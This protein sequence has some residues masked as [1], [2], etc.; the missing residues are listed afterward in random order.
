MPESATGLDG[1]QE[2]ID[3]ADFST[4][5]RRID[6]ADLETRRRFFSVP[7]PGTTE[8]HLN[9][10][11]R[12]PSKSLGQHVFDAVD[13][14]LF[15]GDANDTVG[16]DTIRRFE[17]SWVGPAGPAGM[18]NMV[19]EPASHREVV[20]AAQRLGVGIRYST[21]YEYRAPRLLG[22]GA[23]FAPRRPLPIGALANEALMTDTPELFDVRI[24]KWV[25]PGMVARKLRKKKPAEHFFQVRQDAT[26]TRIDHQTSAGLSTFETRN[27]DLWGIALS[28]LSPIAIT[29]TSEHDLPMA[30]DWHR[31]DFRG[32]DFSAWAYDRVLTRL[33]M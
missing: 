13:D 2:P 10:A 3:R 17:V 31:G 8:L 23:L 24:S 1:S 5:N 29:A 22:G 14:V 19:P 9:D 30:T 27:K 21:Y 32:R 7:L 28:A 16:G 15:V 33:N 4:V 11:R 25:R 12:K 26:W 18:I 6:W 20:L